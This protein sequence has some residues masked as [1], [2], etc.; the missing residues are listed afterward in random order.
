MVFSVPRIIS[1]G[2]YGCFQFDKTLSPG[3]CWNWTESTARL[4]RNGDGER[5]IFHRLLAVRIRAMN[6]NSSQLPRQNL[7]SRWAFRGNCRKSSIGL[8][9]SIVRARVAFVF[10]ANIE[11]AADDKRPPRATQTSSD[12]ATRKPLNCISNRPRMCISRLYLFVRSNP[13]CLA[14]SGL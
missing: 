7:L 13:V 10:D 5:S 2:T 6:L 11:R 14:I 1:R 9:Q 8:S 12:S 3:R 4:E